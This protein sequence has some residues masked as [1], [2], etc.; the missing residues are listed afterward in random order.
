MFTSRLSAGLVVVA[1]V[2]VEVELA[3]AAAFVAAVEVA[4]TEWKRGHWRE[5]D[6]RW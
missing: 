3:F 2:E 4:A 6:G 5:T 1:F